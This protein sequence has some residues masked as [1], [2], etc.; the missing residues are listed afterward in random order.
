MKSYRHVPDNPASLS[1]DDVES[2]F[3]DRRGKLWVGAYDAL[4]RFDPTTERFQAYRS[5][6]PGLSEYRAITEDSSGVLWLASLGN[7]L[8]RFDPE[9]GQFTI[10]RNEPAKPRSLSNDVVN[11]VYVDRSGTVWAGTNHGLSRLDQSSRTFTSYFARDGLADSA[12]KAILEDERGDLWVSTSDGLSR[13][14]PSTG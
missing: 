8:Q 7:G 14:N 10:Y 9:R 12:V 1:H 3:D 11:S 4:N 13:F 5:A 2:L 6:V